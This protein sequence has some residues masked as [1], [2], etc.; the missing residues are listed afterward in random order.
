MQSPNGV[1]V[2][3]NWRS[4]PPSS[5]NVATSSIGVPPRS[6]ISANVRAM[7]STSNDSV[8]TPSGAR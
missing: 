2:I 3:E 5:W 8:P 7:S 1:R 4:V 6:S